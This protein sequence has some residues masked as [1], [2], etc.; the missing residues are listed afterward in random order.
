M[1]PAKVVASR[2][3][4]VPVG[5]GLEASNDQNVVF[6]RGLS[7]QQ[8]LLIQQ[9]LRLKGKTQKKK[10][11]TWV[12]HYSISATQDPDTEKTRLRKWSLMS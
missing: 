10:D 6:S 1:N 7:V 11:G 2:G 8:G 12:M 4:V 5:C 3:C 9:S